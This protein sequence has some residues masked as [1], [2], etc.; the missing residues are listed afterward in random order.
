MY[1]KRLIEEQLERIK[2]NKEFVSG[3]IKELKEEITNFEKG[4]KELGNE[5]QELKKH[6]QQ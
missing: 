4:L 6:L 2:Y 1:V 5:E 3:R